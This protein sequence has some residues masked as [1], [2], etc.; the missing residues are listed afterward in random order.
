MY[1]VPIYK[2]HLC[3]GTAFTIKVYHINAAANVCS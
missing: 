2:P 3:T 1:Q